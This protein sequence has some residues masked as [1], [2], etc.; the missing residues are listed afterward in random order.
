M[1][2]YYYAHIIFVRKFIGKKKLLAIML[3]T[4]TH[5]F[6]RD[7]RTNEKKLKIYVK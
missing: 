5:N 4:Y 2:E 7:V 3:I 1:S 6:L